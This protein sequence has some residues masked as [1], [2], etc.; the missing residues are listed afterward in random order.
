MIGY[1]ARAL[2]SRTL[3][4]I[5]HKYLVDVDVQHLTLWHTSSW[6]FEVSNVKL[7]EGVTITTLSSSETNSPKKRIV[8]KKLKRKIK[9]NKII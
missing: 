8:K 9:R 5:L 6:E 3:Q 2:L 4:R 1:A 7:R